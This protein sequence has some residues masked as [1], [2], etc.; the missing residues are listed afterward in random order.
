MGSK[1]KSVA[2]SCLEIVSLLSFFILAVVQ[3]WTCQINPNCIVSG[4]YFK[5]YS[6]KMYLIFLV[7]IFCIFYIAREYKMQIKNHWTEKAGTVWRSGGINKVDGG[8]RGG[9]VPV[10]RVTNKNKT[11]YMWRKIPKPLWGVFMTEKFHHWY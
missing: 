1:L 5:L 7:N 2:V 6:L 8:D 11:E 10:D 9:S 3:V 4:V